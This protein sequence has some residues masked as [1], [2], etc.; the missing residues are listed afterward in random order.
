[1]T[2]LKGKI[3]D[4]LIAHEND[5]PRNKQIRLGPSEL[6]GCREYIR[7]IVAGTPMQDS[8]DVWP[9]AAVVGTLIGTHVE[10]VCADRLDAL[11]EVPVTTTLPSGVKVTGH[12]DIV[13]VEDN[14]VVDA[15]SKDRFDGVLREGSSLDNLCQV[16]T[17][18][19]GLVQMGV[20]TEGC[21]AHLIYVDRSGSQQFL[22]EKVLEWDDIMAYVAMVD[23]RL[24]D[25]ME[26][27]RHVDA[28]EVEYARDLRDKTPPFC[29]S[30][31][32]LCPFRDS[33]WKGSEWSPHEV[34]ED[35]DV[36]EA[37]HRFVQVR[38]ESRATETLRRQ[39]R[40]ALIGVSGVTPDGWAVTWSGSER[41]P[42]LYVTKVHS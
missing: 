34:I 13:L 30:E 10:K 5:K 20:L 33:C 36:I 22:H 17:Y 21:T 26:V 18:A 24:D 31:R 6:G 32:V 27:Q 29:Y 1:V 12:A 42:A 2:S 15:K 3:L 11:T 40:E 35:P 7:N 41:A 39:Y 14:A 28:G 37:V 4:A 23:D 25:V 9:T 16:S 8:G 19:L 38:D